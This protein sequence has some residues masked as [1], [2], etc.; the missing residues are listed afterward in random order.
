MGFDQHAPLLALTKHSRQACASTADQVCALLHGDG[1][2]P[3][4]L[5]LPSNPKV[6]PPDSQTKCVRY[7]MV[8]DR[9][10]GVMKRVLAAEGCAFDANNAKGAG[11]CARTNLG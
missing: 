4:R 10:L 5:L 7:Y 3:C 6:S 11:L 9:A 2:T 1:P 8:F